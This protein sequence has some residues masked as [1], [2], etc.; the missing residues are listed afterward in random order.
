M[1]INTEKIT[2][3]KDGR[4]MGRFRTGYHDGK[5][6]YQYVYGRTYE[7]AE[8]KLRIAH[9]VE[10][11]FNIRNNITIRQ[12]YSEWIDS[13]VNRVKESTYANYKKKFEN[14]IL[15]V[16]GDLLCTELKSAGINKFINDK[17][18]DG[19]SAGYIKDII[20]VFKSML[21]YVS[22]EYGLNISI[23]NITLPKVERKQIQKLDSSQEKAILRHIQQN[24]TLSSLGVLFSLLMG[25]RIG[26]VCGLMWSDVDFKRHILN[27]NRTVQRISLP[28]GNRKTKVIVSV[29]KSGHS[30]R[31]IVIPD[32]LMDYLKQLRSSDDNYILSDSKKP[33]EPRTMQNRYKK[34]L[35][36]SEVD[37]T[38]YHRLRHTFATN[39]AEAGFDAKLLS[40]ILGHSDVNITFNRYIHPTAE[41]QQKMM[42]KINLRI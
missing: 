18:S 41:H 26:E 35:V 39:C 4:Y 2:I 20:V 42:K 3:R 7:E 21:K 27:I 24:I 9:E 15:P 17:L 30:V 16:F 10:M 32:I 28:N 13:V 6:I 5:I 29:P 33:V 38:N 19:L 8:I 37:E 1:T 23:K 36:E 12:A 14:H 34:I 25:L 40:V 31:S 11:T 22:D